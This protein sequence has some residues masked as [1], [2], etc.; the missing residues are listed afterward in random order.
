[1]LLLIVAGRAGQTGSSARG[2]SAQLAKLN[3][4]T[5]LVSE[6]V[7]IGTARTVLRAVNEFSIQEPE[8]APARHVTV[9]RLGP[10]HAPARGSSQLVTREPSCHPAHVLSRQL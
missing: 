6:R 4:S 8:L 5:R 2:S 1:M 10:E 9:A 7:E 3:G